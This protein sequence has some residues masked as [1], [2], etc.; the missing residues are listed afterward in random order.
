MHKPDNHDDIRNKARCF[1]AALPK[2]QRKRLGQFFTGIPLG[3]LL[4]NLALTPAAHT[5]LDPM[6][7]HGDLLDAASE[8]A[9]ERGQILSRLDGIE[10]DASTAELC[11]ERLGSIFPESEATRHRVVSGDAFSLSAIS[12]LPQRS[13]DVAITNPPYVRYQSYDGHQ[14]VRGGL[15]SII[16]ATMDGHEKT[17]WLA[18]ANGYSGLAD[19]SI[20][21]SMLAALLVAREGRIALVLPATW[22]N[23]EYGDVLR[24]LLLRCFQ[25]E[26]IVEDTQPGWFSTALVRTNLVVARRLPP[27]ESGVP[28]GRRTPAPPARFVQIGPEAAD[29]TSLVGAAFGTIRPEAEMTQWLAQDA[30][31]ARPGLKVRPFCLESEWNALR[32]R[33]ARRAWFQSVE[34][35]NTSLPLFSF[36]SQHSIVLP[37]ALRGLVSEKEELRSLSTLQG[38]GIRVG[39]GLRTGCNSFFYVDALDGASKG[40]M[41]VRSSSAFS[42]REV[43]VPNTALRPVLRRQSELAAFE[44]DRALSGYVLDLRQWILPEEAEI[45]ARAAETYRAL[46]Q[47]I[48]QI[49]P[50]SL[51]TFVREAAATAPSDQPHKRVPELSAV[52]TNVRSHKPGTSPPRFWYMLPDFMPR[53]LPAAFVPRINHGAPWIECVKGSDILIDANFSTFW[54]TDGRWT[55]FALKALLNSAWCQLFMEALGTPMG[56]GAL[57]LEAVQIGQLPLPLFAEQQRRQLD[58]AGHGLRRNEPPALARVNAIMLAALQKM[59]TDY[60]GDFV[61]ALADRTESLRQMRLRSAA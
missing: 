22:R 36:G 9:H 27:D 42:H 18:L 10:T 34:P 45:V 23:R 56:G 24:Y 53:H 43:V 6:A 5:V 44:A 3:K 52:R 51:A 37:D 17:L 25:L 40:M 16:E 50:E 59:H 13:Y 57:K 35:D 28:L 38:N 41:R 1:E 30:R 29:A 26:Y 32:P 15:T 14:S 7:G 47:P 49:M 8:V 48:P 4:A 20:P 21:A 58:E 54:T 2:E 39:Q 19:M 61:A 55:P 46:G 12:S 33:I 31:E 60:R 11:R